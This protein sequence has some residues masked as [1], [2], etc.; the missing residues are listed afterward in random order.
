MLLLLSATYF[1]SYYSATRK[2]TLTN[3][4][5]IFWMNKR[6][7]PVVDQQNIFTSRPHCNRIGDFN[8]T[9]KRHCG[10]WVGQPASVVKGEIAT[11]IIQIV[12]R[13]SSVEKEC[14]LCAKLNTTTSQKLLFHEISLSRPTFTPTNVP[15]QSRIWGN[16]MEW[17]TLRLTNAT[18]AI[19][20]HKFTQNW[21]TRSSEF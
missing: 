5:R 13:I 16:N 3:T 1:N 19:N 6:R 12:Q 9:A 18:C 11:F 8:K 17:M 7:W 15:T 21:G 10:K 20:M 14:V 4:E 2:C